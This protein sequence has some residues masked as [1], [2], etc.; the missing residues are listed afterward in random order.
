M[1]RGQ[2]EIKKGAG[3]L[4]QGSQVAQRP[5]C[6]VPYLCGYWSHPGWW[7]NAGIEE[8]GRLGPSLPKTGGSRGSRCQCWTG[9]DGRCLRIMRFLPKLWEGN[10]GL[11]GG[12]KMTANSP[13]NAKIHGVWEI[14]LKKKPKNKKT[15]LFILLLWAKLFKELS[16]WTLISK[17]W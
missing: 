5:E 6:W 17:P 4:S 16:F 13:F 15:T 1:A 9:K 12:S 14:F 2:G 3:C 10:S 7:E 11:C 8:G